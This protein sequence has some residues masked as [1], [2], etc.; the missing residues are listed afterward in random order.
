MFVFTSSEELTHAYTAAYEQISP[1]QSFMKAACL[2]SQRV[3]DYSALA[4]TGRDFTRS[5]LNPDEVNR[6]LN[7]RNRNQTLM[8][9]PSYKR[10]TNDNLWN[11]NEA[12][13]PRQ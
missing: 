4:R 13:S 1:N 5:F 7:I 9:E 10:Q 8:H 11:L 12:L 6:S 2:S 3:N